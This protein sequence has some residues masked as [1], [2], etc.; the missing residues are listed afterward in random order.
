MATTVKQELA[1]IA[2]DAQWVLLVERTR[3]QIARAQATAAVYWEA[4]YAPE[5]SCKDYSRLAREN[6]AVAALATAELTILVG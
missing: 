4:A 5:G 1:L 2:Q 6:E 3:A